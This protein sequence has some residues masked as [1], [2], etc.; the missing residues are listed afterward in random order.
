MTGGGT[1]Q[2][3][4]R[5]ALRDILAPVLRS[6]GFKGSG[7]NFRRT[8]DHGDWAVVNVQSSSFGTSAEA[9]CAVNLALAPRPWIEWLSHLNGHPPP[10]TVGEQHGL[11]R[12]RLRPPG[13]RSDYWW[14]VDSEATA[15]TAAEEMVELLQSTGLPTLTRLL[16]R[17]HLLTA[18]RTCELGDFN[19]DRWATFCKRAEA[20]LIAE[21]GP[22][23]QLTDLLDYVLAHTEPRLAANAERLAEWVRAQAEQATDPG[24][25]T[26]EL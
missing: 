2:D 23:Q 17:E 16:D 13:V 1:A 11:Y 5:V 4:L 3:H 22:S 20:L 8:N 7:R 15:R 26:A 10:M 12:D 18:V 21:D 25:T 24:A 9:S 14:R 6:N 19:G